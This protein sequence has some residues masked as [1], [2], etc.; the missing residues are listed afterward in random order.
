MLKAV[1]DSFALDERETV[2]E[3][4]LCDGLNSTIPA[5][6]FFIALDGLVRPALLALGD[7]DPDR[8]LDQPEGRERVRTSPRRFRPQSG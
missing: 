4:E 3:N 8:D 1:S 7:L 2:A 5:L 6:E